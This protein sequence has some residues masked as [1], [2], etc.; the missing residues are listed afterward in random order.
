MAVFVVGV[1]RSGTSLASGILHHLGVHMGDEFCGDANWNPKGSYAEL[2]IE[3][4]CETSFELYEA[5]FTR[6]SE[7][8]IK[9]HLLAKSGLWGNKSTRLFCCYDILRQCVPERRFIV[10]SRHQDESIASYAKV[11]GCEEHGR[12]I[13]TAGNRKVREFVTQCSDPVLHIPFD[14]AINEHRR[15]VASIAKFIGVDETSSAHTF[16]DKQLRT[17]DVNARPIKCWHRSK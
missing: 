17:F 14:A 12:E 8:E 13:I 2:K 15:T 1:P 4:W 6:E 16:P 10:T 9:K 11:T 3:M 7:E 5:R